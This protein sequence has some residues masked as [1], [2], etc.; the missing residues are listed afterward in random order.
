[1]PQPRKSQNQETNIQY[2]DFLYSSSRKY[3]KYMT[4]RGGWRGSIS[5]YIYGHHI[6]KQCLRHS[7]FINHSQEIK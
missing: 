4:V 3:I 7:S 5:V 2:E 6:L 1:M